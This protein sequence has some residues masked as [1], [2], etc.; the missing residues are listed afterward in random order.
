[1]SEETSAHIIVD[2]LGYQD[3]AGLGHLLEAGGEVDMVAVNVPFLKNN[4]TDIDAYPEQ[5]LRL[6]AFRRRQGGDCVLEFHAAT[7]CRQRAWEFGQEAV[8]GAFH[9]AAV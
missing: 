7:D 8:A 3:A 2:P 6:L 1:M 9:H 5:K 4:V